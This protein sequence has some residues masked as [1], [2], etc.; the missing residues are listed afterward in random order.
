M[1]LDFFPKFS[2]RTSNIKFHENASS[3][4]RVVP[5]GQTDIQTDMTKLTVV[6]RNFANAPKN[7]RHWRA[8]PNCTPN[9][10]LLCLLHICDVWQ[11]ISYGSCFYAWNTRSWARS[12]SVVNTL[13]VGKPTWHQRKISNLMLISQAQTK[14]AIF[15][16]D[17]LNTG[18]TSL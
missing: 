12:R 13:R 9:I 8:L 7:W 18:E 4:S 5:H 1:K 16:D 17:A 10:K 14:D 3:D 11:H 2:G 15:L 6:F